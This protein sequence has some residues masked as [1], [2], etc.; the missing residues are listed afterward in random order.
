MKFD[1]NN[2]LI[3]NTY[4]FKENLKMISLKIGKQLLVDQIW[5]DKVKVDKIQETIQCAM[6]QINTG[7]F[8][9]IKELDEEHNDSSGFNSGKSG[10]KHNSDQKN[11]PT[12][13]SSFKQ[14][15]PNEHNNQ[16]ISNSH[17]EKN[18]LIDNKNEQTEE[19][20]E[21]QYNENEKAIVFSDSTKLKYNNNNNNN[22]KNSSEEEEY[23]DINV[24]D[25]IDNEEVSQSIDLIEENLDTS[26]HKQ[27]SPTTEE[28]EEDVILNRKDG[29]EANPNTPLINKSILLISEI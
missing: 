1:I 16:K 24:F 13:S 11:P 15:D 17:F 14:I 22:S 3:N 12:K 28:I 26:L 4:I 23:E 9:E 6:I 18:Y 21:D 10:E 19:S 8:D 25:N 20:Y 2:Q 27:S 7:T 5:S 29:N